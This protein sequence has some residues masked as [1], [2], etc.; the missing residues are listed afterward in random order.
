MRA[1]TTLYWDT[2][3]N[4]AGAGSADGTWSASGGAPN[5]RW[6]T[7]A[8]GTA[9]TSLWTSGAYAVFSAGSDNTGSYTVTVSGTQNVAGLTVQEG[10]P[11]LTSGVLNFTGS[12]PYVNVASGSTVTFNSQLSGSAGLDKTGAG[13]MVLNNTA[14]NWTGALDIQAGTVLL[15]T[16][17][18]IPDASAVT[19]SNGATL[20]FNWGTS[21]T[22]ASL[23][24]A[25]TVD[26]RTGTLT[27]GD[28]ANT[29]FS[30]VLQ[31]SYGTLVKQGSGSLTL[32]GANTYSGITTINAGSLIVASNTALGGSTWGNTVAN[33]AAL[34]FQNNVSVTE[35]SFTVTGTGADG[36]GA[37]ANL[38]GNNS[39][40]GQINLGG[41][42]SFGSAA[43]NLTLS[44]QV[45]LGSNALTVTGAGNITLSGA[46]TNSGSVTK[47]GSGTLTFSGSSSNSFS[48]GLAIN[49]GTVVFNKSAGTN[50]TGG[51]NLTI[52]DGV[53]AAG[54]AVLRLDA[55][56]QIAD[57]IPLVAINADG[58]LALNN[59]AESIDRIAGSGTIDT[60]TSG[61][62]TLGI[63][64][65]SSTFSGALA[66]SG[67]IE[68][69]GSGTLS[70][71]G[72]L[73]FDGTLVL[74]GGTLQLNNAN[75]VLGTLSITGNTV[76]DFAG[77]A[78]IL[79][80]TNFSIQSGATLTIINWAEA[81][82]FFSAN[83][84]AGAV[85]DTM[86]SS[87]MNQVVFNGYTGN[88]TTW[89]SYDN[90]VRPNVPE[91]STYGALV[92]ATILGLFGLSRLRARRA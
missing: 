70:L 60:G 46:V 33:G 28:A 86:G 40:A 3:G 32:S 72:S 36:S 51:G 8:A 54:S 20:L 90:Q 84:W 17:N 88:N 29:T 35:G 63:N 69:T 59:V 73:G 14:N 75:F 80:V 68:K 4:T 12:T 47:D 13:T 22:I 66:G 45:D 1:Q 26:F 64:S 57:Y 10:N 41:A 49:N 31:D 67:T 25:G 18:V 7:S 78:S 52:G 53:G 24:G 11:T 6:T 85:F 91:P 34:Q 83:S 48:G 9:N 81:A 55:A 82:D 43:G 77:T 15:N 27:V 16:S 65:G 62:L 50:A 19:V 39:L 61:Y 79:D 74:A 2:N 44:G 38:S 89:A 76:L 37:L 92:L 71:T 42:T 5:R 58:R 21:E 56:N 30:G 23:A 87:P